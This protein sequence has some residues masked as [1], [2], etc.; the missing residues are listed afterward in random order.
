MKAHYDIIYKNVTRKSENNMM[1]VQQFFDA[2]EILAGKL[3]IQDEPYENLS[4]VVHS[5]QDQL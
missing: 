2:L 3:A 1:G 5:I 4:Y